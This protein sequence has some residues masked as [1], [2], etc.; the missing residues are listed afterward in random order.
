MQIDSMAHRDRGP[1]DASGATPA[2]LFSAFN[3]NASQRQPITAAPR[4]ATHPRGG[5]R[6]SCSARASCSSIRTRP[7]PTCS[8]STGYGSAR[9]QGARDPKSQLQGLGF[10][11]TTQNNVVT[12]TL[13]G[14]AGF[15]WQTKRGWFVD[16]AL[17]N[18][19]ELGE[20]VIADPVVERG[21]LTMASFIPNA[22]VDPC[23]GGGTSFFYAIPMDATLLGIDGTSIKGVVDGVLPL[24]SEA[25][26][27]GQRSTT[28]AK[29][30][31]EAALDPNLLRK[32]DGTHSTANKA[33]ECVKLFNQ[34]DAGRPASFR[35]RG[36]YA[37]PDLTGADWMKR[38]CTK[39][40]RSAAA[41]AALWRRLH[42]SL[43]ELV[44]VMA[45]VAILA[46][47]TIANYFNTSPAGIAAKR[48]RR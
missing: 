33:L 36:A 3:N 14:T 8:R 18:Q 12:R 42:S 15:S 13:T 41:P 46:A 48:A 47:M 37:D 27:L 43:I 29:T 26:I 21:L 10:A 9:R 1:N 20:R 44:T 22:V 4:A 2:P 31:A 30:E 19:S 25:P 7:A 5:A 32:D 16:L 24:I 6:M 39:T 40:D 45:I 38:I 28:L 23:E 34:V 17:N 35:G 11:E